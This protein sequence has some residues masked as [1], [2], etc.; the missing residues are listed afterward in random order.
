VQ[1][2]LAVLSSVAFRNGTIA[3]VVYVPLLIISILRLTILFFYMPE[4]LEFHRT[5]FV[6]RDGCIALDSPSSTK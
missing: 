2:L 6:L 3:V 1:L 4:E 5:E